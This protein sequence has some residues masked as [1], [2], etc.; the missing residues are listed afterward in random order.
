MIGYPK[1]LHITRGLVAVC[2]IVCLVHISGIIFST[3]P[4][5][6]A[7]KRFESSLLWAT[8]TYSAFGV[9]QNGILQIILLMTATILTVRNL[10]YK[11]WIPD[12]TD[13]D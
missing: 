11:T 3:V 4:S 2:I 13:P 5:V 6:I 1:I 9:V 8:N 7:P 12:T 10:L